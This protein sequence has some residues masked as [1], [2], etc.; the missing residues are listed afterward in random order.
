MAAAAPA[1]PPPLPAGQ[2]EDASSAPVTLSHRSISDRQLA[3]QAIKSARAARPNSSLRLRPVDDLKYDAVEE[4]LADDNTALAGAAKSVLEV[5]MSIYGWLCSFITSNSSKSSGRI[6]SAFENGLRKIQQRR[7][8]DVAAAW[9]KLLENATPHDGRNLCAHRL[10]WC[11]LVDALGAHVI[12]RLPGSVL[13]SPDD[14]TLPAGDPA[15]SILQNQTNY[16]VAGYCLRR[17]LSLRRGPSFGGV[18]RSVVVKQIRSLTCTSSEA[19]HDKLPFE[20]TVLLARQENKLTY[21]TSGFFAYFTLVCYYFSTLV[22]CKNVLRCKEKLLPKV[23]ALINADGRSKELLKNAFPRDGVPTDEFV[24]ALHIF[25]VECCR[26]TFGREAVRML[27]DRMSAK[28][29]RAAGEEQESIRETL[30][31]GGSARKKKGGKGKKKAAEPRAARPVRKYDRQDFQ[32]RAEGDDKLCWG[33]RSGYAGGGWDNL[34]DGNCEAVTG[35]NEKGEAVHGKC[36][37]P[38]QAKVMCCY[39]CSV[40]YHVGCP[41]GPTGSNFPPLTGYD[42]PWSS[43]TNRVGA[44]WCPMCDAE[45]LAEGGEIEFW[46]AKELAMAVSKAAAAARVIRTADGAAASAAEKKAAAAK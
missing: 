11:D 39:F 24:G 44:W 41:G 42:E 22:T 31:G 23:I 19:K 7:D 37:H 4:A 17:A 14:L 12:D 43:S 6:A 26:G 10:L 35:T 5:I 15:F 9:R 40:V 27:M 33:D 1:L 30:R 28:L 34:Q 25:I 18:D 21:A 46:D 8:D 38:G 45:Y 32:D 2:A 13:R 36:V 29:S 16:F 20:R 3:V